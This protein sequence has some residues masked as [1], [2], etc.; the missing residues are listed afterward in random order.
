MS[1]SHNSSITI[2]I[3][4]MAHDVIRRR[5]EWFEFIIILSPCSLFGKTTWQSKAKVYQVLIIQDWIVML[6]SN[7]E[8]IW[9]DSIH[10]SVLFSGVKNSFNSFDI[11]WCSDTICICSFFHSHETMFISNIN[12]TATMVALLGK[13]REKERER[14]LAHNGHG[15]ISLFSPKTTSRNLCMMMRHSWVRSPD[16][17]DFRLTRGEVADAADGSSGSNERAE[18]RMMRMTS[19]H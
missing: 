1:A 13:G 11:G 3:M 8:L 10:F 18:R 5:D 12:I 7:L 4:I 17:K 15:I 9:F 16:S 14:D 19:M 6:R 2:S